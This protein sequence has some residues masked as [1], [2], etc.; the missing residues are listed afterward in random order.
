MKRL[1]AIAFFILI[2]VSV[3]A[4]DGS[5]FTTIITNFDGLVS[6]AP[7]DLQGG[8]P[9]D[10]VNFDY[11]SSGSA[12]SSAV[13]LIKRSGFSTV[14]QPQDGATGGIYRYRR[15][16]EEP[17]L[18]ATFGTNLYVFSSSLDDWVLAN[19]NVLAGICACTNGVARVRGVGTAWWGLSIEDYDSIRIGAGT[20]APATYGIRNIMTDTFLTIR[21]AFGEATHAALPCT[22]VGTF[23]AVTSDLFTSATSV[24]PGLMFQDTLHIFTADERIEYGG[25]A[26]AVLVS[27]PLVDSLAAWNRYQ[28]LL[29]CY[30]AS[31]FSV[32]DWVQMTAY[33]NT[34]LNLAGKV[35]AI[36]SGYFDLRVDTSF[37]DWLSTNASEVWRAKI[38][39]TP[40]FDT[41]LKA[42]IDTVYKDSVFAGT[43]DQSLTQYMKIDCGP[44]SPSGTNNRAWFRRTFYVK[45]EHYIYRNRIFGTD[46][47][48]DDPG[49]WPAES[50]SYMTTVAKNI[51]QGGL[52]N[53]V[54]PQTYPVTRDSN[55]D[56]PH[57]TVTTYGVGGGVELD[58][59]AWTQITIG[60]D[61]PTYASIHC[62][63]PG[64]QGSYGYVSPTGYVVFTPC[65]NW[66]AGCCATAGSV[67]C[68]LAIDCYPPTPDTSVTADGAT[69]A[70][71][72]AD[73]LVLL[74]MAREA[75][76]AITT[77]TVVD[78]TWSDPIVAQLF[79]RFW[80]A[81]ADDFPNTI[82]AT[83]DN[84]PDSITTSQK[85][86]Y[87]D[88]GSYISAL[89]VEQNI[90]Y[91]HK[92]TRIYT[93][94]IDRITLEPSAIYPALS[95]VGAVSERGLVTT[96]YGQ[97]FI[98][99]NGIY[100]FD[101]N[102]SE[103]FSGPVSWFWRDSVDVTALENAPL[104]Y[105]APRNRLMASLTRKGS[106]R[107][108]MTLV[109]DFTTGMWS[110]YS[111]GAGVFAM[112]SYPSQRPDLY[113][114]DPNPEAGR[115]MRM[116]DVGTDSLMD[117]VSY[118]QSGWLPLSGGLGNRSS[119]FEW[120]LEN[121][122]D[123]LGRVIMSIYINGSE[124]AEAVDTL[125]A[126]FTGWRT[127]FRAFQSGLS[128]DRFSF[129]LTSEAADS[130]EITALRIDHAPEGVTR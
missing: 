46:V 75:Q 104:V 63:F 105:D 90:L 123:V 120:Y 1:F 40:V 18:L 122:R 51:Q 92:P 78:T 34:S 87:D 86:V 33:T 53:G 28:T 103:L 50:L 109:Y 13:S 97:F 27:P 52:D 102:G 95:T 4:Q 5:V 74:K 112:L 21:A 36:G 25:S 128:G 64:F 127:D 41:I 7:T 73:S 113:W 35:A 80:F 32:D 42:V 9:M 121:R 106:T 39:P 118:W 44:T 98:G 37:V 124:T 47:V 76:T 114:S 8:M 2:G 130:L 83:L 125:D 19:N 108:D 99:F 54:Y 58:S 115:V 69:D 45:T 126:G 43:S 129:R 93:L 100:H 81:G 23:S 30:S 17:Q 88:D 57:F 119:L 62:G 111:I 15:A 71:A 79:D 48:G 107:N 12:A 85:V 110:K 117:I 31:T 101:G 10:V 59:T 65:L 29:R 89:A 16:N 60:S 3:F 56:G 22:L 20:P 77:A 61:C 55:A 72:D 67:V 26:G 24:K 66:S 70:F 11:R 96:P 94:P 116:E 91:A 38:V 49:D 84:N 14:G 68:S 6:S 82:G